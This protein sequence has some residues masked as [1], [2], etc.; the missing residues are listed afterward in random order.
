MR[1]RPRNFGGSP[2][3]A[4]PDRNALHAPV[5]WRSTARARD[6]RVRN[7]RRAASWRKCVV[8]LTSTRAYSSEKGL[9]QPFLDSFA[10]ASPLSETKVL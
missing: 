1:R 3:T 6:R 10:V 7:I 2:P 9:S 4:T 8:S 5:L